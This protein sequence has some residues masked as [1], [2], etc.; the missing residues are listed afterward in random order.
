MKEKIKTF[1]SICILVVTVPYVVTFLFQGN[2]TSTSSTTMENILEKES[3]R[4]GETLD[5]ELDMEEY[6]VGILAK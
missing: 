2:K 5:A 4:K 6:L 1:F 3:D